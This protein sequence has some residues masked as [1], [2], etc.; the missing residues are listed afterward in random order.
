MDVDDPLLALYFDILRKT[1]LHDYLDRAIPDSEIFTEMEKAAD[2]R[3]PASELIEALVIKVM[4][5]IHVESARDAVTALY[6]YEVGDAARRLALHMA[7]WYLKIGER[8]SLIRLREGD[9][10]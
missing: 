8:L 10:K 4:E 2:M 5:R 6:G 9:L 3:V 7:H 1:N